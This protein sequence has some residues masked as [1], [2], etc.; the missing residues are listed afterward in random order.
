MISALYHHDI[1]Y[2]LG[3]RALIV[4][5]Y[6]VASLAQ[7]LV[8]ALLGDVEPTIREPLMEVEVVDCQGGFGEGTPSDMTCLFSPV[9]D[10]VG[11]GTGEG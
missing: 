11:Y 10:W 6:L 5:G 2:F 9:G 8:D 1:T 7:M 3:D 4:E